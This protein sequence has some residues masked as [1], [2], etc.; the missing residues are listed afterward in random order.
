MDNSTGINIVDL[1]D[2]ILLTILNKLNNVDVL[3]SLIGVNKR[4]HKLVQDITFIRSF[5]FVKIL[6]D[7]KTHSIFD[8]FCID[9]LPR[10]QH[11]IECLTLEPSWIERILYL[12]HFPKLYKLT[13]ANIKL[14][15]LS[16]YLTGMLSN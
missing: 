10:I 1:S 5:D 16:S 12:G 3:Y 7:E 11:N 4:L 15:I 14:A 2:E 13:L 8:R 6:S 9:V